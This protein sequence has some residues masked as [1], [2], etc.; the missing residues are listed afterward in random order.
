MGAGGRWAAVAAALPHAE[1]KVRELPFWK[2][3]AEAWGWR[4][5]ADAGCGAGFHL[6]L[7]RELG[8]GAAGFDLTLAALPASARGAVSVGDV[9]APP[10]RS[11]AFDAVL[12]L[13]NTIA[14]L[15]SRA[16]QREGLAALAGLIRPGGVIVLQGEDVGALVAA[17]PVVRTRRLNEAA[18]H[19]R[20]FER[21]G[22]R[23]RML[24]GVARNGV[25]APLAT[26]W[27][28][29]T[30]PAVVERMARGLGLVPVALPAPPP[31]GG[32]GWWAAFSAPSP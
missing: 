14:L 16:L 4:R 2:A 26:A 27:L 1:R 6:S 7:L 19:V 12:C 22:R 8:I 28:L 24:A 21:A 9:L 29:P 10:F 30:S 5:V 23:V 25:D 13:G 32:S 20:V 18:V 15:P 17:G 11:G 31:P 3:L